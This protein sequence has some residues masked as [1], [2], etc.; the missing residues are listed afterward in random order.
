M[1]SAVSLFFLLALVAAVAAHSNLKPRDAAPKFKAKAVIDDKVSLGLL[2][3]V[4]MWVIEQFL[5]SLLTSPRRITLES[6]W[7]CC[8]TRE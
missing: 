5:S 8:F 2:F 6:G 3:A 4:S 7:Y 1:T